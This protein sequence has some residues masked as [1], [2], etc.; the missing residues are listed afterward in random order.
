MH[1]QATAHITNLNFMLLTTN[2]FKS[3]GFELHINNI[4]DKH[5]ILNIELSKNWYP[6]IISIQWFNK[7]LKLLNTSINE[8]IK[9]APVNHDIISSN[10]VNTKNINSIIKIFLQ[11]FKNTLKLFLVSFF[12][13]A[14]INLVAEELEEESDTEKWTK[15]LEEIQLLER[16]I[17]A[18][19]LPFLSEG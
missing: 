13:L 9:F 18:E 8:L 6:L 7:K 17:G 3:Y 2:V 12:F 14:R 5:N 15:G 19:N 11:V 1:I 10:S 16:T 4:Q